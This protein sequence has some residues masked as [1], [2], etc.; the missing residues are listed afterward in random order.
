MPLSFQDPGLLWLAG[1]AAAPVLAHLVA[2]TRPREERLPTL[3][4]LQRAAKRVWRVRRP[5]DL[6]FLLLRILAILALAA[7]FAR[8]I[9]VS[10]E[11]W[12][13]ASSGKH[14]VV[15]VDRTGS[16][17]GHD[18][19]GSRFALAK[20]RALEALRGAGRLESVNLVWMRAAPEAVYPTMGRA[21]EPLEAALREAEVTGEAGR[22]EEA[23]R[24]ALDRLAETEGNRELIVV[25]DFQRGSWE[26]AAPAI[27]AGVSV[28]YLPVGEASG[29]LALADLQVD[30]PHPFPGEVVNATVVVRN[31]SPE[32]RTVPLSLTVGSA[33]QTQSLEIEAWGEAQALFEAEAPEG[34]AEFSI[35]AAIEGG[36]DAL[37]A[38]D[39]RWA[40]AKARE[41]IRVKLALPD[42]LEREVWSRLL[43]SLPWLRGEPE[44]A[45]ADLLIASTWPEE[46]A[47]DVKALLDRGGSLFLR[48]VAGGEVAGVA[49]PEALVRS[50]RDAKGADEPGWRLAVA[51][52]DDAL[53][54]LFAGGEYGDPA[55]GTVS[56]RVRVEPVEGWGPLLRYE[57]G[58]P[59]LLRKD[60]VWWWN[61]PFDPERSTWPSQPGFLP[62]IGEAMLL[63]APAAAPL[64]HGSATPGSFVRWEPA[65]FPDGGSVVLL[66]RENSPVPIEEDRGSAGLAYRTASPVQPGAYRWA[67]RDA[68]LER[69]EILGHTAVNFPEAEMEP[70]PVAVAAWTSTPGESQTVAATRPDWSKLR[71]GRPLW[72]WL[73]GTALAFFALEAL[74]L[75]TPFVRRTR[76][77]AAAR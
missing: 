1:A 43:R 56:E 66:D 5:R 41:A 72:H 50:V 59:A 20:A 48:P 73:V 31:F 67:V 57:D 9:W 16:M 44:T 77:T 2:R 76:E 55:A 28:V 63:A 53:F 51:N 33:R 8:P 36:G 37:S 49:L 13:G 7:A 21:L 30:P 60:A 61:L 74:L 4:F 12:A 35:A 6:F 70:R 29:N 69:D 25:S 15:I 62:L 34:G 54:R 14:L 65:Q 58:V 22:G 71:D 38:D 3:E 10:A 75:A 46:N 39:S 19:V 47:D 26:E 64:L 17:A 32:R 11:G 45:S 68:E 42:G 40:V 24:L 27:P 23:M 18:P 52:E